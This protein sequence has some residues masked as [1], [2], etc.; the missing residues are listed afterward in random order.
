MGPDVKSFGVGADVS[1]FSIS[2]MNHKIPRS[3]KSGG[4]VTAAA[5]HRW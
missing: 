1:S 5:G 2:S 3:I 4:D